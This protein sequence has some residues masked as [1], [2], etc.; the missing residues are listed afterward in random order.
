MAVGA[1]NLALLDLRQ[2]AV[3]SAIGE[4]LAD[5]KRLL[6]W[7][8]V[9]KIEDHRIAFPA[10]G[11]GVAFEVL[12]QE[13]GPLKPESPF[14]GF[15]LL[16]VP[17]LVR[18]V[19]G[20]VIGNVAGTA[21]VVPLVAPSFASRQTLRWVSA[22]RSCRIAGSSVLRVP[23]NI[24]SHFRRTECRV[25]SQPL[26]AWRSLVAHSAGG[27]AVAGSNPV[28]PTSR[29]PAW[30]LGFRRSGG[31]GSRFRPPR[32]TK[33]GYRRPAPVEVVLGLAMH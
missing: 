31:I 11:A 13:S 9:V 6:S 25:D 18:E 27:R 10:V 33:G 4:G 1:Y 22:S 21:H 20:A 17:T 32:G 2:D 8:E 23:S 26:G 5:A 3:P 7:I 28:A 16:H 12:K 15:G 19:V 29:K 14:P 30:G 24:R